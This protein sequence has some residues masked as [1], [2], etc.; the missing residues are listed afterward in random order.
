MTKYTVKDREEALAQLRELLHPGDTV[1]TILRHVSRS[2]ML[3][4][5]SPIVLTKDGP[6]YVDWAVAHAVGLPLAERDGIKVGGCGMDMGFHLVYE[7]SHVLFPDGF[8]C[9]GEGCPAN[10][11][12]NA[13]STHCAVCGKVRGCAT[14]GQEYHAEI[15]RYSESGKLDHEWKAPKARFSKGP[16][17]RYVVCS[18]KCAKATWHHNDG[19]YAINHKWL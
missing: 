16:N 10:D 8:D 1:H 18:R 17:G 3:R 7:L 19:G 13:R 9:I 4:H 12:V 2:G 11:H 15:H 6:R 5:I 14:C